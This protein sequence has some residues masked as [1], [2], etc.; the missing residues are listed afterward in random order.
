MAEAESLNHKTDVFFYIIVYC[1]FGE[2]KSCLRNF[3]RL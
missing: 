3:E 2:E 1:T